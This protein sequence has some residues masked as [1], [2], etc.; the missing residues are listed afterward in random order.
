[1]V[2][3]YFKIFFIFF[4]LNLPILSI[5]QNPVWT[6]GTA[7][8]IKKNEINLSLSYF[9]KYGITE[10]FEIQAKP[11]YWLKQPHFNVK[12]TW[13]TYKGQKHTNFL[14]SKSFVIGSIHGI[15]YPTGTLRYVQKKQYKNLIPFESIIPPIFAFRNELLITTNIVRKSSCKRRNYI[16]TLKIGTKFA[17]KTGETSLPYF[18]NSLLYRETSIYHDKLLWYIGLDLDG[19]L[20]NEMNYNLDIDFFSIGLKTDYWAI[21]H[22]GIVYWRLGAKN[23]FRFALGYKFSYSNFP[24][25]TTGFMPFADLTF[26]FSPRVNDNS[27]LFKKRKN[28]PFDDRKKEAREDRKREKELEKQRKKD[29]KNESEDDNEDENQNQNEDEN[30]NG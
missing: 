22:K 19:K 2:K 27:Q 1:M 28:K 26:I 12:K 13:F 24:V 21:E 4:F 5:A 30:G 3:L 7:R 23:R 18:E 15:N 16:F 14:R 17:L 29:E 11:L 25:R 8:T 20:T 6:I 9:S 10:T